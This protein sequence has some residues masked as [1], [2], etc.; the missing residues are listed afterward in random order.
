MTFSGE[1][2]ISTNFWVFTPDVFLLLEEG[3]QRFFRD[4]PRAGPGAEILI[5]EEV[6][7]MLGEGRVR[8]WV[9]KAGDPFFGITHPPDL[10]WAS[11]MAG[12]LA[13]RGVYPSPIWG[14]E[15]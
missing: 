11:E 1:E 5:P 3:L 12:D 14:R 6:G 4:L 2:T 8:V 13:A 7:R 10:D 15:A 9:L